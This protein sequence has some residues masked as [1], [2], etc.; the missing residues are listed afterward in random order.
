MRWLA[1]IAVHL[2]AGGIHVSFASAKG[3]YASQPY[4]ESRFLRVKAPV[5]G[6]K[7]NSADEKQSLMKLQKLEKNFEAF[8][9]SPDNDGFR[10]LAAHWVA[11]SANSEHWMEIELDP[12]RAKLKTIEIRTRKFLNPRDQ[13]ILRV[14]LAALSQGLVKRTELLEAWYPRFLFQSSEFVRRAIDIRILAEEKRPDIEKLKSKTG[15][16]LRKANSW[17]FLAADSPTVR[18]IETLLTQSTLKKYL[19]LSP[20][21]G[22]T[23]MLVFQALGEPLEVSVKPMQIEAGTQLIIFTHQPD[24]PWQDYKLDWDLSLATGTLWRLL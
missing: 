21:A 22:P 10:I 11:V 6:L 4:Y 5:K 16:L 15:V 23:R 1:F 18:R 7:V 24:D 2:V 20:N 12:K 8:V 13:E 3:S 17:D 14:L 9:N 19:S